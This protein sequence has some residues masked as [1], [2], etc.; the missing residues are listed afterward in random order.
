M[1]ARV[2]ARTAPPRSGRGLPSSEQISPIWGW[3]DPPSTSDA[4]SRAAASSLG[5]AGSL[6]RIVARWIAEHEPVA[7]WQIEDGLEL[8]HETASARV[9]ELHEGGLVVRLERKGRTPRGRSCWLYR[10]TP[11]CRAILAIDE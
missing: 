1:V 9:Y 6:R 10:V 2:R 7:E 5:N 3:R 4:N 8:R 11:L